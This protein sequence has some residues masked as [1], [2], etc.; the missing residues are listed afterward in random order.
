[1]QTS[2]YSRHKAVVA[3]VSALEGF[4]CISCAHNTLSFLC[5]IISHSL[6][7]SQGLQHWERELPGSPEKRVQGSS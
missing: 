6:Q 7:H 2:L 4:H 5:C 3:I 1:M